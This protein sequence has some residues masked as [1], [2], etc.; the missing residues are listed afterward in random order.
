MPKVKFYTFSKETEV[1]APKPTSASRHMPQWYKNQPAYFGNENDFN[2]QGFS[3]S[4]V[5]KCMPIF[6]ARLL[7]GA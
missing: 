5:K 7:Y 6:D 4:T 2:K 1:I 3:S